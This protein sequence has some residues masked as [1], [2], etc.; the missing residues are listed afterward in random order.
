MRKRKIRDEADARSCMEA[1]ARSGLGSAEWARSAGIDGRSL[2]AWTINLQR[3]EL[4]RRVVRPR[5]AL[6]KH[7][8][9]VELVASGSGCSDARYVV[10]V[11]RHR[12]EV[13]ERFDGATLRRLLVVLASC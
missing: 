6:T 9:L 4:P 3:G 12:V 5:V 1:A 10:H 2:R 11:G 7:V 8:D 13:G